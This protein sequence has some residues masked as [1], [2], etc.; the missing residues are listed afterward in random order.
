MRRAEHYDRTIFF[1]L[2]HPRLTGWMEFLAPHTPRMNR[3]HRM[4]EHPPAIPAC[5]RCGS[6][7]LTLIG[8][9]DYPDGRKSL[10][11]Y[12]CVCGLAFTSNDPPVLKSQAPAPNPPKP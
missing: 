1:L 6:T 11:A 8:R 12:R 4:K 9:N 10:Y 3:W 7:E 2:F 5:Q